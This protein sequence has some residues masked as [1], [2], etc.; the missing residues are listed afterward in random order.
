MMAGRLEG[1]VALVTGTGGRQGR[2]I[3]RLFA[4]EG[5]IVVGCDVNQ[6]AAKATASAVRDAGWTM[7][8]THPVDL[9]D[10]DATRAWIDAAADEFGGID[11]LYNNASMPKI[12]PLA[13]LSADDWAF[14][15]RNELDLVYHACHHVWRHLV[16]RGG[17]VILNTASVAGL[18]GEMGGV[19]HAATKGGVIAMTR[20]LAVEGAPHGIRANSISPGLVVQEGPAPVAQLSSTAMQQILDRQ[21]IGRPGV[22]DDIA[23]CALYLVS[24]E[25]TW[26]TGANFVV[27]GGLT[28]I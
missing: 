21:L 23:Y 15:M 7:H 22:P 8:S 4:R 20:Q 11:I 16:E 18:V 24:D 6:A 5:A 27:D 25:A 17:G 26:V 13:A 12:A 14:T 28:A 19:A 10:G 2:A 3:A 1:K 9:G